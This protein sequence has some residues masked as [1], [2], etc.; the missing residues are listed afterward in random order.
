MDPENVENPRAF[1]PMRCYRLRFSDPSQ[2]DLHRVGMTHPNNLAFGYGNQACPGRFFAVAEIK[3][4][5]A[6]LL[7]EFEFKFPE[8]KSRPKSQYVNE[9]VFTDQ[10]ARI[11]MR[12]K[13]S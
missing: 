1:D 5:M 4:I 7:Y 3:L 9:N 6:R 2:R 13:R 12:K 8:G 10:T 11:M